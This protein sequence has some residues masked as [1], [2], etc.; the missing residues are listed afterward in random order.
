MM[1]KLINLIILT[2]VVSGSYLIMM[3][4]AIPEINEQSLIVQQLKLAEILNKQTSIIEL[5]KKP[6]SLKIGIIDVGTVQ[7]NELPTVKH[8]E[9]FLPQ[10]TSGLDHGHAVTTEMVKLLNIS[11]NL[12]QVEIVYCEVQFGNMVLEFCLAKMMQEKVDILNMSMS[13]KG[14]VGVTL[15]ELDLLNKI[16]ENTKIV[17]AAGNDGKNSENLLCNLTHNKIC[18]G[19]YNAQG[20]I[21]RNSNFGNNVDV[22]ESFQ[23]LYSDKRGTSFSAPIHAAKLAKLLLEGREFQYHTKTN[24]NRSV[25]STK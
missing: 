24:P 5:N 7:W 1:T 8:K 11:Q 20:E 19:G 3:S 16:S 14:T 6:K 22:Y 12:P 2:L 17:I 15:N 13:I 18:V 10:N 4:S 21:S 25:A 23:A 9:I